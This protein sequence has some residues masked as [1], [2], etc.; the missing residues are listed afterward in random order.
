MS[1]PVIAVDP[2][3]FQED[4][5]LILR[6]VVPP[7]RLAELRDSYE[8]I[9][10]RQ[11]A[12]W[13]ANR[14]PGDPPGGRWETDSQPRLH[15]NKLVD[16]STANT[17][18]F[19]LHDNTLGVSKRLMRAPEVGLHAM[20]MMC[21][22]QTDHGP[23]GWHRDSSSKGGPPLNGLAADMIANGPGHVQWNIALYDDDVLWVVPGSHRR[24]NT[25]EEN[26]QLCRDATVPLPGGKPVELGAGDGV[27]YMN[28]MLH[29][30]SNY[31]SKLRRTIHTG[32]QSFGGPLYRYFH[33]WW[34]LDFTK[35]LPSHIR[36][37]FEKWDRCIRKE[38]DII[39]SIYRTMIKLDGS[40]FH[41][42]LSKLHPG[43]TGKL[44]CVVHMCKLAETIHAL[45]RSNFNDLSQ[46]EQRAIV[47]P[48]NKHLY[49]DVAR[50]FT[51]D[52]MDIVWHRFR[53]LDNALREETIQRVPGRGAHDSYYRIDDM[54][55]NFDLD[56]FIETW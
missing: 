15:F 48:E 25:D 36:D 27:V 20:F 46:A 31:S 51:A 32:Y 7:E 26:E 22:P 35:C 52:E 8:V 39:E 10:D 53:G 21:S 40:G 19:C 49:E 18:D 6:N 34:D 38:H 56:D 2:N 37:T 23:G 50:R 9:V 1:E 44:V 3:Q 54:P 42:S 30:P 17:V 45:T 4:G 47:R 11:R 16:S 12:I 41:Q 28:Y 24:G 13:A 5:Y 29:W 43:Q 55:D 33:L 14:A